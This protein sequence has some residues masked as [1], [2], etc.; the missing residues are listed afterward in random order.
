M[1]SV[2]LM[3]ED[4]KFVLEPRLRPKKRLVYSGMEFHILVRITTLEE[5]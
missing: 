5:F 4:T 2:M 1:G 3:W